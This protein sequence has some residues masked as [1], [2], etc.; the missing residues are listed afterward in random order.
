MG[1]STKL[2]ITV[3]AACGFGTGVALAGWNYWQSWSA[4]RAQALAAADAEAFKRSPE[5]IVRGFVSERLHDAASAEFRNVRQSPRSQT[6]WCGEVNGRNRMGGM[7]GFTRFVVDVQL[8]QLNFAP[9]RDS[10]DPTSEAA[11]FRSRWS[12]FCE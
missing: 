3:A 7:V 1:P 6:I 11:V 5:G 4:E 9:L 10:T 2:F 12:T 8:E